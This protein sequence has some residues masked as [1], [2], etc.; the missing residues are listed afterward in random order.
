VKKTLKTFLK[1]IGKTLVTI[2]VIGTKNHLKRLANSRSHYVIKE[3]LLNEQIQKQC[4]EHARH[5]RLIRTE[6]R[7]M[8]FASVVWFL[9][10]MNRYYDI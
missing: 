3:I 8:L 4:R 10:H 1:I 6:Y 5:K 7:V 9:D 2:R